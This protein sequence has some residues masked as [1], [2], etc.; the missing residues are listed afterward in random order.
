MNVSSMFYFISCCLFEYCLCFI[1]MWI[2]VFCSVS[3][4][5]IFMCFVSLEFE[6]LKIFTA[7][8]LHVSFMFLN[9]RVVSLWYVMWCFL[10]IFFSRNKVFCFI[11]DAVMCADKSGEIKPLQAIENESDEVYKW[12]F[13]MCLGILVIA[14]ARELEW[15]SG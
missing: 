14:V 5:L 11:V 1:R 4:Y 9:L 6:I 15:C 7:S 10:S 2:P 3:V 12:V 8:S 13:L